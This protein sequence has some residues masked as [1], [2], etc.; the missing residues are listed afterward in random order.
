MSFAS[1]SCGYQIILLQHTEKK[2]LLHVP[3]PRNKV[4]KEKYLY[5]V[6]EHTLM[7]AVNT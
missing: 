6:L 3:V 7:F 4:D 1:D 5:Q 2:L